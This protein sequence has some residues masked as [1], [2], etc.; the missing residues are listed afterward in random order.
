MFYKVMI[1]ED[2]D[3]IRN[4]LKFGFDWHAHN[5]VVV[6]DTHS[7]KEA[8]LMLEEYKPDIVLMDINLPIMSGL[9]IIEKTQEKYAY[10]S[11]IISG[12]SNFAY[13]QESI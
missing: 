6:A 9:E 11:I 4:G 13:A 2:E 5:C 12:Y 8:L 3:M 1:V 10:S 7:S